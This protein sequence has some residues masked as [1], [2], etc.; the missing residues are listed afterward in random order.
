MSVRKKLNL[1]FLTL[2]AI[3]YISLITMSIQFYRVSEKVE[4]TI[5]DYVVQ[6]QIGN[7]LPN[8]L[9]HIVTSTKS[10]ASL[11][12]FIAISCIVLTIIIATLLMIF[13]RRQI[14]APLKRVGDAAKT[15]ADGDLSI[16]DYHHDKNDE[17]GELSDAFNK[18]KQNFQ[19]VIQNIQDNTNDLTSSAKQLSNN[20]TEMSAAS[21]IIAERINQTSKMALTMT[22]AVKESALAM[23]ETATGVQRIAESTQVLHQ[24]AL[25]TSQA[26]SNGVET[27]EKA[28]TQMQVIHDSTTLVSELTDKLNHQSEEIS[29]ITNVITEITNQTNLLALNAAIEAARAGEHGKGFAV[30]ADEVRKLAEQSNQSATQIV[31]LTVDIQTDAKNVHQAVEDGLHSVKEGVQMIEHAGEAFTVISTNIASITDQVEDISATSQQISAS[32]E[33]VSASV[34]EIAFNT[35][36]TSA[37]FAQIAATTEEQS[38][39]THQI[40]EVSTELSQNAQELK[41]LVQKFKL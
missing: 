17:I 20:T 21:K 2:S 18:M 19:L 31:R 40:N 25:N 37:N 1:G 35:E 16:P 41:T 13:V 3:I 14:T 6:Q 32:A 30:V 15:L 27:V 34:N 5:N 38:N 23:E 4:T 24:N 11:S 8:Q 12:I 9:S 39:S 7:D 36:Q 22:G 26:A 28:R 10:I 33:E 29:Q